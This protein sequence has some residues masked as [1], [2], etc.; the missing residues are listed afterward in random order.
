[1]I[2]STM[3]CS[4]VR[5]GV[6]RRAAN[7]VY[8]PAV[9]SFGAQP[10]AFMNM[11]VVV[12]HKS[13]AIA[14]QE[15]PASVHIP[16]P[17]K[18]FYEPSKATKDV[19]AKELK[20]S[21]HNYAPMPVIF[22]KGKACEVW[23]VDG[24]RYLDFLSGYSAVNQGHCHPR[25]L[26][27]A[28]QQLQNLTLSS[29][30]FHNDQFSKFCEYITGLLGYDKFL[31]MNTGVEASETAVKLCRRW[32]YAKKGIPAD[33]AKVV[34]CSEN[35]WGRSLAAC[36]SSSDPT[37]YT[38]FGPFMPGFQLIDFNNLDQL[39]EALSDPNC[40]GFMVEPIQGE[41]GVIVPDEG[42]FPAVRKLCDKYNVLWVADEVQTGLARTG[43]LLC[44]QHWGARPDLVCLGK[45]LSG[46]IMPVSGVLADDRVMLTINPGE[47]GSTFGG[48]PLASAVATEALKILVDEDM[49]ANSLLMGER[50]RGELGSA[51]VPLLKELRGKGLLNAIEC[52]GKGTCVVLWFIW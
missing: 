34:M 23:D 4:S 17:P 46:G 27:V 12:R 8:S 2:Y 51:G 22:A 5:S 48:N 6:T 18:E 42:Y 40:A 49:A 9:K 41:A 47:H 29:R 35:F 52:E 19:I 50:F 24:R 16:D 3:I 33:K 43:K 45:A 13:T 11:T 14:S 32:G 10:N 36:S 26:A 44:T 37:C 7:L 1:M 30:A 20:H 31:P 38:N 28:S 39:E 15:N 25:L 21:A